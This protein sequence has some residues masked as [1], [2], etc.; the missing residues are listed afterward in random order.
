MRC[1]E[2]ETEFPASGNKAAP[3][4]F[5]AVGSV[6][7]A[8]VGLGFL[9]PV[10]GVEVFVGWPLVGLALTLLCFLQVPL[11]VGDN[12][13]HGETEPVICCPKCD[14]PNRIRPWSF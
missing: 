1:S 12:R 2:C 14:T 9:L 3:G 8:L 11:A 4:V 7:L 6:F 5:L 10:L 13:T